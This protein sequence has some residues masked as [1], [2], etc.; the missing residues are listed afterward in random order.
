MTSYDI[1]RGNG[2]TL[3]DIILEL[4]MWPTYDTRYIRLRRDLIY[5]LKELR[6]A[7]EESK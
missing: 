4:E 1:P 2:K 5:D 6:K 3:D 7:M